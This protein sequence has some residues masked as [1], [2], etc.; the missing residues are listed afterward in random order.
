MPTRQVPHLLG[1]NKNKARTKALKGTLR[2]WQLEIIGCMENDLA[3]IHR[4]LLRVSV[5]WILKHRHR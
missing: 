4:A 2:W 1:L 5:A 3:L